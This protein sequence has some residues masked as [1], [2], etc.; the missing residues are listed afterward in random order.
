[1]IQKI[2]NSIRSNRTNHFSCLLFS[3]ITATFILASPVTNAADDS[4]LAIHKVIAGDT[5]YDLAQK[6]LDDSGRWREF[7]RINEVKN[8]R[9]LIPGSELLIPQVAAPSVTVI[10]THGEV[11]LLTSDETAGKPIAVGDKLTEGDKV[12]VGQNSYLSVQFTDGTIVRALSGSV[13][14]LKKARDPST[15][16]AGKSKQA[17]RIMKLERGNLDISVI[18]QPVSS[19]KKPKTN[20]FEIIT[21]MAVAAVRG[22]R[23]DVSVSDSNT[24]SGVTRGSVDVRQLTQS[25]TPAKHALLATGTGIKVDAHGK[26]GEV[27]QLLPAPDLSAIPAALGD[28]DQLVLSWPPLA[29]AANYHVRI[30]SD[31]NM[32]EVLRNIES[33]T[34]HIRLAGLQ[35][36]NYTLGVRATDNNGIIGFEAIRSVS[37]KAHPSYPFYLQPAYRQVVG[38]AITLECTSVTEASAYHLQISKTPDFATPI[39]DADQLN[40]CNYIADKLENGRYFWRVASKAKSTDGQYQQGPFSKPSEFDVNTALKAS[41]A[42]NPPSAYWIAEPGL[43]FTSQISKDETFSNIIQEK[44]L[45]QQTIALDNLSAGVYYIRLQAKD[46]EGITSPFSAPR[47]VEIKENDYLIERTWGDKA[48]KKP[49]I[50]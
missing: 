42:D 33:N 50:K 46:A 38:A 36:G 44:V 47:M 28:A 26:L 7:L 20:T 6:Y 3:L 11:M 18:P 8:P 12:S 39:V 1:M 14:Q 35:D 27:R 24:S 21:P 9:Q 2:F 13:L 4:T 29:D 23:F 49:T 45:E 22:T 16:S 32:Q 10:F 43:T 25:K 40:S 37:I 31:M 15:S 41:N 48:S 17:N 19:Q 5:L 30:A 34:P